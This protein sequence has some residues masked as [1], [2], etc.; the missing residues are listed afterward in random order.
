MARWEDLQRRQSQLTERE[1]ELGE[2]IRSTRDTQEKFLALNRRAQFFSENLV[3]L[4]SRHENSYQIEE[5]F[6][7]IRDRYYQSEGQFEE[8]IRKFKKEKSQL[9]EEILTLE[10]AKRRGMSEDR[11]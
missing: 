9:E 11:K 4:L 6:N 7:L 8:Q 5:S 2:A 1:W 3:Y 10:S